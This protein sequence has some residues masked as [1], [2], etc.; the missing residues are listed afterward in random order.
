MNKR[1]PDDEFAR[2]R[3]SFID[4]DGRE[5]V[6]NCP[7][8]VNASATLEPARRRLRVNTQAI[9]SPAASVPVRPTAKEG[10]SEEPLSA[11]IPAPTPSLEPV[12]PT[13]R[14][15]TIA[16]GDTGHSYDTIFGPYLV[17]A[18]SI[19]VEDP[20]IR[21]SH[22]IA[23]FVR[24]CETVVKSS[25]VQT[26]SLITSYDQQTDLADVQGEA[27]RTE[28]KPA[29]I[30]CSSERAAERQAARPRNSPRQRL[31]HQDR[32]RPGFLPEARWLVHS[33]RDGPEL[34]TLSGDESRRLPCVSCCC[35]NIYLMRLLQIPIF[36]GSNQNREEEHR[37]RRFPH[38]KRVP[39]ICPFRPR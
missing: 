5:I 18:K 4:K 22:Q 2:I 25:T 34:A 19:V 23:N 11:E 20:Y 8:S 14:H 10:P 35:L 24:F 9:E 32:P 17:G 1:K 30:R 27:G 39:G 33:R 13:E 37:R 16:Y 38:A 7:E 29:G 26:L 3:L 36:R 28:A 21:A 6:V 15:Y 12:G 31:D